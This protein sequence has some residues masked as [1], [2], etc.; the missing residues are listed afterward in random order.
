ME[1][2]IYK[3]GNYILYVL[4]EGEIYSP[5]GTNRYDKLDLP[6][7]EAFALYHNKRTMMLTWQRLDED[8]L[9][10]TMFI[11]QDDKKIFARTLASYVYNEISNNLLEGISKLKFPG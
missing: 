2:E 9:F 6:M 7:G 11:C 3:T 10:S 5:D 4:K 1:T 8:C